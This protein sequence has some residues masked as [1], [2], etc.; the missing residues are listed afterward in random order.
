MIIVGKINKLKILRDTSV[1]LF[2]GNDEGEDVLLP[3]KYVPASFEIG[4]EI[5]VFIYT[6]SED[7][8]V[9]TNLIPKVLP[10][11]FG[12]LTV[13]DVN[14]FGAFLEWGL[15]KDLL[16]PFSYQSNRMEVGRKYLVHVFLDE[17]SDRLVASSKIDRFLE[18]ENIELEK[19]QEVDLMICNT[20]D[21]GVNVIINKKYKGL[22]YRNEI[23]QR[24]TPG[25]TIKGFIKNVRE[26]KRID[27]SLQ[28]QG[29]ENIDLDAQKVLIELKKS[30]GKL[31]L[32]DKSDADEIREKLNMSKKSYK[33]AI[34]SLFKQQ[35]IRIEEFHIELI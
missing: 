19:N 35:K 18:L 24:L 29:I 12:Y 21:L 13:K 11:E 15:E 34:G 32:S 9:A 6:D 5:E 8:L 28:K 10:G 16:C 26:D 23:F 27:V 33:K 7:R 31:F 2:L 17:Q 14:S 1:G 3:N 4:D 30:G 20:T 25:E 22:L